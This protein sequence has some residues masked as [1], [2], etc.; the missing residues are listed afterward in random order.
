ML[1]QRQLIACANILPPIRSC[2]RWQ[3]KMQQKAEVVMIAK[4][5]AEHFKAISELVKKHHSYDCP[6][7]VA[8][9]IAQ[10]YAPFSD[11][12]Q[13]ETTSI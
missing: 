12:V 6:A 5:R 1:L 11:W 9:D 7:I 3:G 4:S 2:F 8:L 10:A 13:Q